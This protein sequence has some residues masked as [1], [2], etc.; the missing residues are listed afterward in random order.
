MAGVGAP[1]RTEVS[2]ACSQTQ[3]PPDLL[4][5]RMAAKPAQNNFGEVPPDQNWPLVGESPSS[6]RK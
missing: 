5:T 1:L 6:T 4:Q 3:G 2:P